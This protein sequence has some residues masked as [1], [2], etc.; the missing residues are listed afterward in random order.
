[1]GIRVAVLSGISLIA[2]FLIRYIDGLAPLSYVGPFKDLGSLWFAE[3]TVLFLITLFYARRLFRLHAVAGVSLIKSIA[4]LLLICLAAVPLPY[5]PDDGL[6]LSF[7]TLCFVSYLTILNPQVLADSTVERPVKKYV[8]ILSGIVLLS[9]SIGLLFNVHK[10][11]LG[12]RAGFLDAA[13]H[14]EQARILKH[15]DIKIRDLDFR[16]DRNLPVC[17]VTKNDFIFAKFLPGHS[18]LMAI[19]SYVVSDGAIGTVLGAATISIFFLVLVLTGE[20]LLFSFLSALAFLITPAGLIIFAGTYSHITMSA[21]LLLWIYAIT[22]IK[23]GRTLLVSAPAILCALAFGILTRPLTGL[24]MLLLP[25]AALAL[26]AYRSNG[27]E[28]KALLATFAG[29][30]LGG[31]LLA[32]H[33]WY[34]TGSPLVSGYELI[35]GNGHRPGFHI[36]PNRLPFTLWDGIFALWENVASMNRLLF[37]F[38]I[39]SL[40]LVGIGL[41]YGRLSSFERLLLLASLGIA[42]I[43]VSYWSFLAIQ[44]GPRFIFE[45]IPILIILG[46]KGSRY[47]WSASRIY[48][49]QSPRMF[50]IA[51]ALLIMLC[52]SSF[53]LTNRKLYNE[54]SYQKKLLEKYG[55]AAMGGMR[56]QFT[57]Q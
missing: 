29:A 21:M 51:S 30:L 53:L 48:F 27:W 44:L 46:L 43:H 20:S 22:S 1:M 12:S 36:A 7:G 35:Y 41:F 54:Y 55:Q 28:R 23:Q 42:L 13:C 37:A 3:R 19:A 25:S 8:F 26:P 6:M 47:L 33:N 56:T 31:A 16:G 50:L 45:T 5:S 14:L 4:G 9:L 24:G 18:V 2:L 49:S 57:S 34:L 40:C 52:G 17:L 15:G 39:P 32:A 11:F 10:A 38:P